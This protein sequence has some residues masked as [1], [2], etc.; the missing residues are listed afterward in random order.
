MKP[1]RLQVPVAL[2]AKVHMPT[3]SRPLWD[4]TPSLDKPANR[5]ADCK[6]TCIER[7]GCSICAICSGVWAHDVQ[8][9]MTWKCRHLP[10]RSSCYVACTYVGPKDYSK[11]S[12][13]LP[14]LTVQTWLVFASVKGFGASK[15]LQG[16]CEECPSR[17]FIRTRFPG[18]M[19]THLSKIWFAGDCL[20]VVAADTVLQTQSIN[21][22]NPRPEP[23]P[24]SLSSSWVPELRL[25]PRPLSPLS[26]R[27]S[28]GRSS[29]LRSFARK[30]DLLIRAE[31]TRMIR[32]ELQTH[33]T[34]GGFVVLWRE[35]VVLGL[36]RRRT[37]SGGAKRL[38]I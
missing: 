14:R 16:F 3:V 21:R 35:H 25:C 9:G 8:D 36:L 33:G 5:L 15:F 11:V 27:I 19:A 12:K 30:I 26:C 23:Q 17:G 20:K 6:A 4:Q 38:G 37:E 10:N 31:S 29:F 13:G 34:M 28:Q 32:P 2:E 24:S 22:P 1:R 7:F 18:N